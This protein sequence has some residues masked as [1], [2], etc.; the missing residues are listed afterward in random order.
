[1]AVSRSPTIASCNPGDAEMSRSPL[2]ACAA[3]AGLLATSAAAKA[4]PQVT[5]VQ[6]H[7]PYGDLDLATAEGARTMLERIHDA[8]ERLCAQPVSPL[9]PRAAAEAYRCRTSLMARSVAQLNAPAVSREYARTSSTAPAL[10]A[11]A[12]MPK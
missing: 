9:L 11:A 8:L 10:V 12:E 6:A 1:M 3:L 5:V 2:I 7:V 4:E